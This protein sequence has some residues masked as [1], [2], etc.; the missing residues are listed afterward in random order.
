MVRTLGSGPTDNCERRAEGRILV[1]VR[2]RDT[3][4]RLVCMEARTCL[5]FVAGVS[6]LEIWCSWGPC[7]M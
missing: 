7:R 1:E 6:L 2:R 5:F 4:G 3:N